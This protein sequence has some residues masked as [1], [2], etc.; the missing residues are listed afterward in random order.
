MESLI[1]S[2][3]GLQTGGTFKRKAWNDAVD[4]RYMKTGKCLDGKQ[5]KNMYDNIK[6]KYNLFKEIGC[7]SGVG[8]ESWNE[9]TKI[10]DLEPHVWEITAVSTILGVS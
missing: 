8:A 1:N 5:V 2:E 3:T 6:R 7:L 9:E 4:A 10:W